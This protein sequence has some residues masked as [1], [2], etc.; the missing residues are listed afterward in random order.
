M[1]FMLGC[2]PVRA[3]RDVHRGAS[4]ALSLR[5]ERI[6][7]CRIRNAP[8][9]SVSVKPAS[10]LTSTDRTATVAFS[11]LRRPRGVSA[12]E[13]PSRRAPPPAW[14]RSPLAPRPGA[15]RSSTAGSRTR[16][17]RA[18]SSTSPVVEPATRGTNSASRSST[19]RQTYA[20]PL[21]SSPIQPSSPRTRLPGQ[22]RSVA[23]VGSCPALAEQPA[24][25]RS[26]PPEETVR[27]TQL[28]R[29]APAAPA[30]VQEWPFGGPL[31]P[32]ENLRVVICLLCMV[33][34][35]RS[36]CEFRSC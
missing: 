23:R 4:Y 25:S 9:C 33:G 17:A 36:R 32:F 11:R 27:W 29:K 20:S 35:V 3:R 30:P 26:A 28:R 31:V 19:S 21:A 18:R 7:L 1:D 14:S 13:E 24:P 12:W 6:M 2:T 16:L 34:M 5:R 15:A 22:F 10:I 8:D